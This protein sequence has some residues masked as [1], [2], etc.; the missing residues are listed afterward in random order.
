MQRRWDLIDS[1]QGR[2]PIEAN[3]KMLFYN[4]FYCIDVH[5]QPNNPWPTPAS[6]LS[7]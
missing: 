6:L 5:L 2:P 1:T 3:I 4:D 7:H